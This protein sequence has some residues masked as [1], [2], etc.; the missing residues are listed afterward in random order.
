MASATSEPRAG[1]RAAAGPQCSPATSRTR[2]PAAVT[3]I[4]TRAGAGPARRASRSPTSAGAGAGAALSCTWPTS[5][6][7]KTPR[8]AA[9]AAA[10]VS[11]PGASPPRLAARARLRWTPATARRWPGSA[12]PQ[13]R[14]PRK[15]ASSTRHVVRSRAG[16][17]LTVVGCYPTHAPRNHRRGAAPA[18]EVLVPASESWPRGG[19]PW[20]TRLS[21]SF[22]GS[23]SGGGNEAHPDRRRRAGLGANLCEDPCR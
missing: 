4:P 18:P 3:A 17:L 9:R 2:Q 5:P 20:G 11:A 21:W 19:P 16:L 23:L 15:G 8:S 14:L 12:P 7:S 13:P 10:A 22:A 1:R 6:L